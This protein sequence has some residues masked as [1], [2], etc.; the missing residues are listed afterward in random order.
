MGLKLRELVWS[1]FT[2]NAVN[3]GQILWDDFL[4]YIR[5]ENPKQDATEL[6]F[7][8]YWSLCVSYLYKEAQLGMG[9][10]STLFITRDLKKYTPSKDQTIFG[11]LKRLPMYILESIGLS[12]T[13]VAGHI[14]ATSGFEPYQ[15]SS[16]Q[17]N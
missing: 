1:L 2:G 15:S 5:K 7:S 6:T 9:D 11:P 13:A 14:V 10:D 12:D 16:P 3:F 8:R 17:P 4:Q